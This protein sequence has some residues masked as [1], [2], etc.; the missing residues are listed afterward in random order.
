M[1]TVSVIYPRREGATFDY[2]YYVNTH[3][4]LVG[5][6]WADAGLTGGEA[7]K[8]LAGADGGDPPFLAIGIIHFESLGH[9]QAAMQGEHAPT[10]LADIANFTNVEPILQ[11]NDRV[12]PPSL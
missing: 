3:L 11:V 7:L 10:V 8:G 2:D 5:K 12:V 9:F 6:L 1:A 4:P